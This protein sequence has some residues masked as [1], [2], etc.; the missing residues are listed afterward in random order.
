MRTTGASPGLALT[1]T[2]MRPSG[3]RSIRYQ[4]VASIWPQSETWG[5]SRSTVA[6]TVVPVAKAGKLGSSW[7]S[8]L[9]SFDGGAAAADGA[10]RRAAAPTTRDDLRIPDARTDVVTNLPTGGWLVTGPSYCPDGISTPRLLRCLIVLSFLGE[11]SL[12]QHLVSRSRFGRG[13]RS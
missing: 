4:T 13:R 8:A 5:S 7:A 11:A 12:A 9:L 2:T 1:L 10:K 6:S 3:A